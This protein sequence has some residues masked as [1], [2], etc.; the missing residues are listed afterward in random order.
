V[1]NVVSGEYG[2]R[3]I[4]FRAHNKCE[5]DDVEKDCESCKKKG[6]ACGEKVF[7][8][9][10]RK[11]AGEVVPPA[12]IAMTVK[13]R[14]KALH[15]SIS[16]SPEAMSDTLEDWDATYLNYWHDIL[17]PSF[18]EEKDRTDGHRLSDCILQ[19]FGTNLSSEAFRYGILLYSSSFKGLDLS[20]SSND[21]RYS[22]LDSFYKATREALVKKAYADVAYASHAACMSGFISDLPFDEISHHARGFLLSFAELVKAGDL[23]SEELFLMRCMCKDVFCWLTGSYGASRQFENE[24]DR[25]ADDWP[26]RAEELYDLAILT[27]PL[28]QNEINLGEEPEWRNKSF[29]YMRLQMLMYRLQISFDYFFAVQNTTPRSSS[30]NYSSFV[31]TIKFVARELVSIV[32]EHPEVRELFDRTKLFGDN[33][34]APVAPHEPNTAEWLLWQPALLAHYK[35]KFATQFFDPDCDKSDSAKIEAGMA[36]CRLVLWEQNK[37]NLAKMNSLSAMRSLFIF[38]LL[39]MEMYAPEGISFAPLI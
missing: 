2:Y 20:E 24:A 16:T 12:Q 38:G 23:S 14:Y 30:L 26:K 31:Q 28:F 22:Y 21:Q 3:K 32:S 15:P 29:C 39:L 34:I 10:R 35:S 7:G 33:E 11:K 6:L 17:L 8:N 19:R 25:E 27:E 37:A 1:F 13:Q 36:N 4:S 5:Y 9:Q 18:M